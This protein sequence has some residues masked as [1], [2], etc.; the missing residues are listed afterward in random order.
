MIMVYNF[1]LILL[2]LALVFIFIHF[3]PKYAHGDLCNP[4]DPNAQG[5]CNPNPEG[6]KANTINLGFTLKNS[7]LGIQ[8]QGGSAEGIVQTIVKNSILLFFTVGGIGTVIYFLWGAVDWIFSGGDKEKV[9]NA[10]KKMTHA[11]IGLAL[12]ALSFVIIRTVGSIVGFDPL[13][14]LQIRGLGNS[15]DFVPNTPRQ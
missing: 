15:V 5:G 11:L 7:G 13:G 10:R 9:A 6:N 4:D 8:A 3:S 1:N 2:A 14:N 12:L